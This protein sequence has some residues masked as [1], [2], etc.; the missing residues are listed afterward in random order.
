MELIGETLEQLEKVMEKW[1]HPL[2]RARQITVLLYQRGARDFS[3]L[4]NIPSSL[5]RQLQ[6][7]GWRLP[8]VHIRTAF[9][10]K[11]GTK[12]YLFRLIDGREVEGVFIPEQKRKTVCFST[13]VG[14]GMG[15]AFC[16]TGQQGFSRNLTAGEIIDQV[17][18]I[19]L[20]RDIR[21]SNVVAMGQGEPL[22]NYEQVLKAVRIINADYGLGI[23]ARRLTISTC[24]L[25][26]AIHRLAAEE[27][28]I[29]L[30]VS[31]HCANDVKRNELVPVNRS[32]SLGVLHQACVDY[33]EATGRRVTLEYI[34]IKD[35]NDSQ[36]DL[37]KL[38]EF[39]RGW[40]CHI[41]L[42]PFNPI[43][44]R[45]FE[46]SPMKRIHYF[47]QVLKENGIASSIRQ[48]RGA[49]IAAACGQLQAHS[50]AKTPEDT[51]MAENRGKS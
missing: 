41:N 51:E 5:R 12:R 26:P 31:L 6:E 34:M 48:E 47:N 36:D 28:Q 33:A 44:D 2:Y 15:C 29:N 42:I 14:C 17:L 35:V 27:L 39:S 49:E 7:A 16:A 30:A 23:A 37:N 25:V 32:Y 50:L 19:G 10:A 22:A 40:L 13:Q 24:G 11:D 20:E 46:S 18:S 8:S 4:T 38:I 21:I 9:E 43:P 1:G 3:E 45:T